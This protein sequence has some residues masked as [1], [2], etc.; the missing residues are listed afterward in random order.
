MKLFSRN[1]KAQKSKET[2][3]DPSKDAL[4][5]RAAFEDALLDVNAELEA[6]LAEVEF[7]A[8]RISRVL[9]NGRFEIATKKS[10]AT[11]EIVN[12][13]P[14]AAAFKEK[15]AKCG[16]EILCLQ[17]DYMGSNT[18]G[19]TVKAKL[20]SGLIDQVATKMIAAPTDAE[21]DQEI[22]LL[23]APKKLDPAIF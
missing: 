10:F 14:A 17:Y 19:Y 12:A 7:N 11:D 13:L 21:Q 23:A 20:S 3:F 16:V 8:E 9:K 5:L 15:M 4:Q 6:C 2:V 1:D 18:W 22:G